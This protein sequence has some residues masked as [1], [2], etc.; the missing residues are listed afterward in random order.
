MNPEHLDTASLAS[1]ESGNSRAG[2]ARTER[3]R[4]RLH[5]SPWR[6]PTPFGSP[7][8]LV[9]R[10]RITMEQV[11]AHSLRAA[12]PSRKGGR[13]PIK[14][15][16]VLAFLLA[17]VG[18]FFVAAWQSSLALGVWAAVYFAVMYGVQFASASGELPSGF[19]SAWHAERFRLFFAL[20]GAVLSSSAHGAA[21]L[22][23]SQ[24]AM[25]MA[26]FGYA[27]ALFILSV[28]FRVSRFSVWLIPFLCHLG[29]LIAHRAG[30]GLL[31]VHLLVVGCVCL[32]PSAALIGYRLRDDSRMRLL[33]QGAYLYLCVWVVA[34][35]LLSGPT[36]AEWMKE[37]SPR[38]K[39]SGGLIYVQSDAGTRVESAPLAEPVRGRVKT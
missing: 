32:I 34:G 21:L 2:F 25:E 8:A 20:T 37:Q 7:V 13:R 38:Y 14:L 26:C 3:L 18:A 19:T 27:V 12:P 33:A 11:V 29:V 24:A 16:G 6:K 15:S 4:V 30:V 22:Y 17:L 39:R 35:L 28:P 10:P 23:S 5:A 31:P 1:G 36:W 9:V